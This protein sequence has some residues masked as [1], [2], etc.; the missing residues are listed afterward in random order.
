MIRRDT[1]DSPLPPSATVDP[2]E[3]AYYTA[4]AEEWWKPQGRF[5]TLH[6]LN[7]VRLKFIC[8]RVCRH[9]G[10]NPEKHLRPLEEVYNLDYN[11]EEYLKKH[12]IIDPETNE[13]VTTQEEFGSLLKRNWSIHPK[14]SCATCHR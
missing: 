2:K 11:A 4:M 9:F 6:R 14:E 7:P 3:V 8:D 1:L 12:K 13:R 10:R 5:A